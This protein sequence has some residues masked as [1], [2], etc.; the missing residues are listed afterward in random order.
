LKGVGEQFPGAGRVPLR[1]EQIGPQEDEFR[2]LFRDGRRG[3]IQGVL[4][5][6][7]VPLA[8]RIAHRLP[9]PQAGH[10]QPS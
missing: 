4:D 7:Q 3:A 2:R 10:P 8:G 5:G 9:K 6:L 1:V